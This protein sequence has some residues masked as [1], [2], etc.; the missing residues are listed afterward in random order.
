MSRYYRSVKLR[1]AVLCP[2]SVL[3]SNGIVLVTSAKPTV[4]SPIVSIF[5]FGESNKNDVGVMS[6]DTLLLPTLRC[7]QK[8]ELTVRTVT[9]H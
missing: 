1:L 4:S 6:I 7:R 3:H 9:M 8:C 5:G 2:N